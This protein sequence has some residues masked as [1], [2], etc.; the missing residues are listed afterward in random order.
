MQIKV[1]IEVVKCMNC[2]MDNYFFYLSDFSYGE[3]LALFNNCTKYVYIN[4]L[5]DNVYND[6]IDKVKEILDFY[7][8]EVSGSFFQNIIDN[9]FGVACDKIDG[10]DI[11]FVANHKK[12]IHCSSDSFEDLIIEQRDSVYTDL[13]N[14]THNIWLSLNDN[15]KKERIRQELLKQG[16]L[17]IYSQ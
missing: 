2:K 9:I 6:F 5:H 1:R 12:C 3:R 7:K 11:D 17:N 16:Y 14:V 15:E 13:P 10:S 4:L 8:I